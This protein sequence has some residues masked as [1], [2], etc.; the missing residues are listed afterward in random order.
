MTYH[1]EHLFICLL[2]ICICSLLRCM[3]RSFVH[4]LIGLFIFLLLSF[5]R[6]LYILDNSSLSDVSFANI[7]YQFVAYVLIVLT[8]FFTEWKFLTSTQQLNN[9]F[10]HG[11]T[12][13]SSMA[14]VYRSSQT[15]GHI[16][17]LFCY[18]PGI[19]SIFKC[20]FRPMIP[21]ELILKVCV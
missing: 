12:T 5:K 1:V 9:Y 2:P 14:C 6:S 7:L 19:L 11:S 16:G 10:F 8:L 15:R 13:I 20:M 4:F 18:L 17:F 3:V 21:F